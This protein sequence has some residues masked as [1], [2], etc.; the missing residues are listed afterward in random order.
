MGQQESEPVA[1]PAHP[2]GIRPAGNAYTAD[3][4]IKLA[5]G[6]F[7]CLPDE[8]IM[9]ILEFLEPVPLVLLGN[10]CKALYAFSRF[11][12]LWKAIVIR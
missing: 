8:I 11:E 5:A 2:L 6:N 9:E 3:T 4:N 7:H 1:L 10:T 12:E